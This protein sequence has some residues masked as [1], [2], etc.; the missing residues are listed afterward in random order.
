MQSQSTD[1][2]NIDLQKYWLSLKRRWF[3]ALAVFGSCTAIAIVMALLQKPDYETQGK[4]LFKINRTSSLTGVGK[5]IGELDPL[6]QKSNPLNTEIEIIKS[7]PLVQ[8]TITA[9]NV[10]EE[11]GTP[12]KPKSLIKKLLKVKN[13]A[14]TDVI[15]I[16]YKS[17]DPEEAA[18]VVNKLMDLYIE[19]N[20]LTNRAEAVA[21]R[22]FI[23]SQL[24]K[25]EASVRQAEAA[26][27]LFKERNQVVALDEEAKSTV[28]V[29]KNLD[30]QITETQAGLA[31]MNTRSI[32]LQKKLGTTSQEAIAINSLNQSSGVQKALAEYQQVE[33]QLAAQRSRFLDT[34]PAI[35]D[36]KEKRATLEALLEERV[37]QSL[38]SQQQLSERN[39]QIGESK[40]KLS[41]DLVKTEVERLALGSR[42]ALLSNTQ[43]MYKQRINILPKLEQ[44]Q[45]ELQRQ[46]EAAQSTYE[47]LL[48]K[49]QEVRVAENQNIGNASIMEFALVPEKASI[50]KP[51]LILALGILLGML[52][53]TATIVILE[54]RDTS[55]KTLKEAKELFG[56][57]LLGTIP[58]FGKKVNQRGKEQEWTIPEILVRA[59]PGSS[60]SEAYPMLQ[61]N[62]KFMSSDKALKVI[63]VT[64]SSPKE[65]KSTVAANLAAATAELG[66][67]VL[68]VDADMR[69]PL[70]H[71]IWGLTNV[72]GLSDV[73]VGQAEFEATV[74]REVMP[75]LD[76]LTSGVMPPNPMALLDSKRMAVLISY[77]SEHYDFAIFDTPPV[78]QAADALSLGQMTD[79]I[80]FVARPGVVD[81][82]S[83]IA[84]KESLERSGNNILGLVVNGV[85]LENE[86]D[87]Y[88]YYAKEDSFAKLNDTTAKKAMSKSGKYSDRS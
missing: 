68:L 2:I 29:I 15:E 7:V 75:N 80:L 67:R 36:L 86:S 50:H 19:K 17:S 72:A 32:T 52:F 43:S 25:A 87:S 64:S 78:I 46:V 9:L 31:D 42:L 62:L 34:H 28:E 73:L 58:A 55:I 24:P 51:A 6:A 44:D 60:L 18:A 23:A 3:P 47:V 10:K 81:S 26:L 79:G 16:S 63:V 39:L 8:K 40:Q 12:S 74:A 61:A 59:V 88:F 13:I 4:L 48:K 41:D 70:Q 11:D 54:I 38:G 21:A 33:S 30:N 71:H 83:A 45:R 22:E 84:A 66:R 76:V 77:F 5:E 35:V 53:T 69:R 27:R 20:L 37:E 65:G 82:T 85:I 1:Y 49:L 56:Y 57:T 14:S